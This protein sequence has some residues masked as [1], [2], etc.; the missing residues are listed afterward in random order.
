MIENNNYYRYYT[1]VTIFD[2]FHM[3]SVV[4]CAIIHNRTLFMKW[5]VYSCGL[6]ELGFPDLVVSYLFKMN[7]L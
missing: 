3:N 4:L 6:I 2:V 7:Y 5:V 1:I